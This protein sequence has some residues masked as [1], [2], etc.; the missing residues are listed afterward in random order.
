VKKLSPRFVGPY[1]IVRVVNENAYELELPASM[2]SPHPVFHVALLKPFHSEGQEQTPHP[3]LAWLDP[4]PQRQW[5]V[6]TILSHRIK[7]KGRHKRT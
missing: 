1:K 5:D 3:Q 6:E 4:D 2:G 7:G